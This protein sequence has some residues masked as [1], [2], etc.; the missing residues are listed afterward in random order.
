MT[1]PSQPQLPTGASNPFLTTNLKYPEDEEEKEYFILERFN[2]ITDVANAKSIGIH[3]PAEVYNGEVWN[4]GT[5]QEK[6]RY[7]FRTIIYVPSLPNVAIGTYPHNISGI[8][9]NFAITDLYVAASDR[10]NFMYRLITGDNVTMDQTNVYVT[11]T[12]NAVTYQG[13]I[14]IEYLRNA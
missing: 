8:N 10:T 2:Q 3:I 14:V 7:G 1:A 11:P 12:F 6:P 13:Y 5:P 4:Y 9:E